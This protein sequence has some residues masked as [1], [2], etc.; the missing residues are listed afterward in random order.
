MPWKN[1]GGTTTEVARHPE[2]GTLDDFDWRV[3]M[4]KVEADGPFSRFA[5]VDRTLVIL[6]G[7]GVTLDVEDFGTTT[8]D[9]ESPPFT[10]AAD[11]AASATLAGGPVEDLNVMTRR[12]RCTHFVQRV[13]V[14]GDGVLETSP[15]G[16][17]IAIVLRGSVAATARAGG[18][19]EEL[20]ARDALVFEG[21]SGPI[22]VRATE[23]A[24]I[25]MVDLLPF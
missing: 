4:A 24:E 16:T 19:S 8:L 14:E 18:P 1:G 10:F 20:G 13:V 12:G 17:G 15:V 11:V 9:L 25:L 23:R 2:A 21:K 5:G 22:D 3:S 6:A 7:A